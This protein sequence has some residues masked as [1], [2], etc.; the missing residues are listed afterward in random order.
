MDSMPEKPLRNPGRLK[1]GQE[2][3]APPGR[4]KGA[5]QH[6]TPAVQ[7]AICRSLELTVP[8]RHACAAVGIQEQ[9]YQMWMRKGADGEEPYAEFARQALIAQSKAVINLTARALAGGKGSASAL[10]FLERRY[11]KDFP[12][13]RRLEHSGVDAGPLVIEVD[14]IA[15]L[16]DERLAELAS[17]LAAKQQAAEKGEKPE[18]SPE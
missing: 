12:S 4:P 11:P 13:I 16:S 9:L 5:T 10:W 6:L 14:N 7:A 18:D 15:N 8:I 1:D 3:K 17:T 2:R